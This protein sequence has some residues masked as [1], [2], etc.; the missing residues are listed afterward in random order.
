M[1]LETYE[2][3][4][5][6]RIL[7]YKTQKFDDPAKNA[8][9]NYVAGYTVSELNKALRSGKK[10]KEIDAECG[11]IDS[12]MKKS[13]NPVLYRVVEW[14]YL[15]NIYNIRKDNIDDMLFGRFTAKG[16]TSTTMEHKNI[17][18]SFLKDDVFMEIA[19]DKYVECIDVNRMFKRTEIDCWDQREILLRRNLD[20]TVTGYKMIDENGNFSRNGKT[21]MLFVKILH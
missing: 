15:Q 13:Y 9:W 4:T 10:S 18:G 2:N 6:R 19:S 8:V 3:F 16:Y 7:K 12:L 11:L 5:K 17:W 1:K 20:F 21:C 14:K